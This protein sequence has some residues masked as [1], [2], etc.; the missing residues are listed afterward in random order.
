MCAFSQ[1]RQP[2]QTRLSYLGDLM[3]EPWVITRTGTGWNHALAGPD[4]TL[5]MPEIGVEIP[6]AELYDG[7]ALATAARVITPASVPSEV[8]LNP[9]PRALHA[10]AWPRARRL[11][12][13]FATIFPNFR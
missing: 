2:R 1:P 11:T 7:L 13:D 9:S 6:M 8:P 4:G 3:R 12:G 5:A 10:A